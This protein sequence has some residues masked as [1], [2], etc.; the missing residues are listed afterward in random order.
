MVAAVGA[1]L[2]STAAIGAE[3][4]KTDLF[5]DPL[6]RGAIARMGTCRFRPGEAISDC[7]FSP[8]GKILATAGRNVCLWNANTGELIRRDHFEYSRQLD[9]FT[10]P[11][12]CF[13]PDGKQYVFSACN[14][15]HLRD[16]ATGSN[17]STSCFGQLVDLSP[18][19]RL[20][21]ESTIDS[22]EVFRLDGMEWTKSFKLFR[23]M[24]VAG[25]SADGKW[26]YS[27]EDQMIRYRRVA[28]GSLQKEADCGTQ[29]QCVEVSGDGRRMAVVRDLPGTVVEAF[30]MA[31]PHASWTQVV[32]GP[33][34][35]GIGRLRFSPN[36]KKLLV[37]LNFGKISVWDLQTRRCISSL[38]NGGEAAAC[39]SPDGSRIAVGANGAVC[40]YDAATGKQQPTPAAAICPPEKI[41]F[42]QG[43]HRLAVSDCCAD[44]PRVWDPRTGQQIAAFP[45]GFGATVG[46]AGK[47]SLFAFINHRYFVFDGATEDVRGMAL[48][49]GKLTSGNSCKLARETGHDDVRPIVGEDL[50]LSS[51][52]IQRFN[53]DEKWEMWATPW[54]QPTP[55]PL[56]W[57]VRVRAILPDKQHVLGVVPIFENLFPGALE[58]RLWKLGDWDHSVT[59][60]HRERPQNPMIHV[61]DTAVSSDGKCFAM[62]MNTG[63]VVVVDV[64]ARKLVDILRIDIPC[65]FAGKLTFSDDCRRLLAGKGRC[66]VWELGTRKPLLRFTEASKTVSAISHD[67]RWLATGDRKGTIILWE[68]DGCRKLFEFPG[69]AAEATA[70]AFSPDDSLLVSGYSDCT[71]ISWGLDSKRWSIPTLES[72]WERLADWE[73]GDAYCA[74]RQLIDRGA[75]AVAFLDRQIPATVRL[76][77]SIPYT[78]CQ[79]LRFHR[80]AYVLD[81]IGTA[82]ARALRARISYVPVVPRRFYEEKRR[83]DTMGDPLPSGAVLRWGADRFIIS[84]PGEMSLAISNDGRLV[85]SGPNR[86]QLMRLGAPGDDPVIQIWDA[87]SG[88]VK[89]TL[90]YLGTASHVTPVCFTGDNRHLVYGAEG[91]IVV[92]DVKTGVIARQWPTEL[93]EQT[94]L[95]LSADEKTVYT[96]HAGG[97]FGV[98]KFP[99][100]ERVARSQISC[101]EISRIHVTPGLV[102][103]D[104]LDKHFFVS[105]L[106]DN[107]RL[108]WTTKKP[109]GGSKSLCALAPDGRQYV[110]LTDEGLE[111]RDTATDKVLNKHPWWNEQVFCGGGDMGSAD[112]LDSKHILLNNGG[113]QIQLLAANTGELIRQ[114]YLSTVSSSKNGRYVIGLFGQMRIFDVETGREMVEAVI[115]PPEDLPLTISGDGETVLALRN[116]RVWQLDPFTLAAIHPIDVAGPPVALSHDGR[117]YVTG[118]PYTVWEPASETILCTV[119]QHGS[120]KRFTFHV[121]GR[122]LLV[123]NGR[124]FFPVTDLWTGEP[125]CPIQSDSAR[126]ESYSCDGR[127]YMYFRATDNV[128]ACCDSRTL[129]PLWQSARQ[130]VTP[131]LQWFAGG[132]FVSIR[133]HERVNVCDGP[134]G[135]LIDSF[136]YPHN[137]HTFCGFA[138]DG[139][140][141]ALGFGSLACLCEWISKKPIFEIPAQGA[142][143][144]YLS[145]SRFV[146]VR[147]TP[148]RTTVWDLSSAAARQHAGES[149]SQQMERLWPDF[150]GDD[151]KRAFAASWAFVAAGSEAVAF[152]H[153]RL[154]EEKEEELI[155]E[156]EIRRL[157]AQLD[158]DDYQLRKAA[159]ERLHALGPKIIPRLEE[160]ARDVKS[161][162]VR[163]S[164]QKLIRLLPREQ[165]V[166]LH[167]A[168]FILRQ[169]GTPQA[170]ELL[171]KLGEYSAHEAFAPLPAPKSP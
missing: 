46:A 41:C 87:T 124:H 35:G 118:Y 78:N 32:A 165:T 84:S 103:V 167:R 163:T 14:V 22:C 113:G 57:N 146:V 123:E 92:V 2:L 109:W 68:I 62:F 169:I 116:R 101:E 55:W 108:D 97:D 49:Y 89:R 79:H 80:A 24:K 66:T 12:I 43:K 151:A 21:T 120:A 81:C 10:R 29:C 134:T 90:P 132:R 8:D 59:L 155:N 159:Y 37:T 102:S 65:D 147:E 60:F 119:P 71:M 3:T 53:E 149:V 73:A 129:Q 100:G 1:L 33:R 158:H 58:I 93:G 143:I 148:G 74:A 112:Y 51:D 96:G 115:G 17:L 64:V 50:Y 70:I 39:W 18:D 31:A 27:H 139:S 85:A 114:T 26:I 19:G 11:R 160:A 130:Y 128:L 36:G 86:I 168:G 88:R 63:E 72:L 162:E 142:S 164:L 133:N 16:V 47:N 48:P 44:T 126:G 20:L 34:E 69:P 153:K 110:V 45:A 125:V 170:E 136:E 144:E 141:Y 122:W 145:G 38:N 150:C 117:F 15:V 154:V 4:P 95:T 171:R 91:Q 7:A 131:Q 99:G 54:T 83:V 52:W 156:E 138:P 111:F 161:L 104:C 9:Y 94:A 30:D 13:L 23:T 5:G 6:P 127:S 98:F 75:A 157:V 166:L 137:E 77:R 40:L 56:H 61:L 76:P 67:G 42:V 121:N 135:K 140:S 28:D 107:R 25:F 105:H 82:A 152:L 106:W